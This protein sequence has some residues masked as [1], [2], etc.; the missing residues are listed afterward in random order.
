[1]SDIQDIRPSI[2]NLLSQM[3]MGALSVQQ[4]VDALGM[5]VLESS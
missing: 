4:Q 5:C 1:M 2:F 3:Q